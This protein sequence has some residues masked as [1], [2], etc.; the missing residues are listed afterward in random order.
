M[1]MIVSG[2]V[3]DMEATIEQVVAC[4]EIPLSIII[5]GV[6]DGPFDDC[7]VLDADEAPLIDVNGIR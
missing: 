6:G 1:V 3:S 4:S 2:H 7:E 5:I